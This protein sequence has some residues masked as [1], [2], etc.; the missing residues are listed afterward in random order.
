[1]IILTGIGIFIFATPENLPAQ[2]QLDR[3]TGVISADPL[4]FITM[5]PTVNFEVVPARIFGLQAGYRISS[6]GLV[7]NL[8]NEDMAFSWT[9]FGSARFYVMPNRYGRG[10]YVGP[11]IEVGRSNYDD[12]RYYF[13]PYSMVGRDVPFTRSYQVIAVGADLG[14]KWVWPSGFSLDVGDKIGVILIKRDD[15]EIK[16]D[17]W[18][19]DQFVFYLL[20]VKMGF[21]F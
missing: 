4:G 1:M 20:S 5:G 18:T 8:I 6:L 14:Y 11:G 21:A 15:D 3:H 2:N 12:E 7:N 16:A 10:F 19:V 9:V 17:S 13:D